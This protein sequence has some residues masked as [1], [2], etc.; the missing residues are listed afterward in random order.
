[1]WWVMDGSIPES[2]PTVEDNEQSYDDNYSQSDHNSQYDLWNQ[3]DGAIADNP[4][5]ISTMG[6]CEDNHWLP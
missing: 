2:L 4:D 3:I 5:D 1:M 6:I